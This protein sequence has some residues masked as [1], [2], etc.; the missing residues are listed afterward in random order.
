MRNR[1]GV[2]TLLVVFSYCFVREPRLMPEI[3]H[4]RHR[5]GTRAVV[6]ASIGLPGNPAEW[7]FEKTEE[8]DPNPA[9]GSEAARWLKEIDRVGHCIERNVAQDDGVPPQDATSHAEGVV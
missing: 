6:A 8:V 1:N 4:Y 5:D 2:V 9:P 7:T 3:F